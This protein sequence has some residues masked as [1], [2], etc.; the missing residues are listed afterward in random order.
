MDRRTTADSSIDLRDYVA[1]L[2][3]QRW[4][5]VLAAALG[6]GAGFGYSIASTPVYTGTAEVLVRPMSLDPL[7]SAADDFSVE[8]EREVVLSSA[9]ARIAARRLGAPSPQALLEHVEVDIPAESRVMEIAYSDPDPNRAYMA[10]AAFADAYLEFRTRQA[11]NAALRVISDIQRRIDE[12]L[13]E[14]EAINE[15]IAAAAPGSVEHQNALYRREVIVGQLSV[16]ETQQASIS[17]PTLGP[18]SV[19]GRRR[20]T[21]P[22]SPSYPLNLALGL[23]FGGFVGVVVAFVRDRMDDRIRE[24]TELERSARAPTLATVPAVKA[25][26][27]NGVASYDDSNPALAE[28]YRRLRN[29]VHLLA[30]ADRLRILMITSAVEQEGKTTTAANLA[31]SL[32][33]MGRKVVLVSADLRRPRLHE[34]LHVE[35]GEGI[36]GVLR[37]ATTLAEAVQ[38]TDI[39][40][41]LI[42]PSGPTPPHPGELLSPERAGPLFKELAKSAD[43]VIVD[44]PPALLV[45]DTM[46]MAPHVD[47]VVLVAR[48]G[49]TT[50]KEIELVRAA[51]DRADARV[52]GTVF[53][54]H[55]GV[56]SEYYRYLGGSRARR[57]PTW[58]YGRRLA[59]WAQTR[60]GDDVE[61]PA[62][63]ESPPS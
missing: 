13:D 55:A 28:S 44:S 23:F 63:R 2:R 42:L 37:G 53:T 26:E 10:S 47:A 34:L 11:L 52:I 41:L 5:I 38:P 18:G 14:L 22:S 16:L 43:Y 25:A 62:S 58:S 33:M 35:N 4:L 31:V 17:T 8:T 36:E 3:R 29:S 30:R 51:F 9:V 45:A 24:T 20:P 49:T 61:A 6:L 57:R 19:I 12:R 1:V 54:N 21:E 27:L 48:E 56:D 32:A 40:N 39:E 60:G 50:R 59:R 15:V 46:S 7:D